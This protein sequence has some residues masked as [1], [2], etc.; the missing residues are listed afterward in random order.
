MTNRKPLAVVCDTCKEASRPTDPLPSRLG[1][2]VT[3]Q[4]VY[5]GYWGIPPGQERE[6]HRVSRLLDG[7]PDG[8]PGDPSTK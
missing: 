4:C 8:V 7:S 2:G 5:C 6:S 1:D 3:M